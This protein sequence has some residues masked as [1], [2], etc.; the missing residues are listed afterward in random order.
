MLG[1][2]AIIYEEWKVKRFFLTNSVLESCNAIDLLVLWWLLW[3]L[4]GRWQGGVLGIPRWLRCHD[5][6]K[7]ALS[8]YCITLI[9]TFVTWQECVEGNKGWCYRPLLCHGGLWGD[10]Q[11][12]VGSNISQ[13]TNKTRSLVPDRRSSV[14]YFTSSGFSNLAHFKFCYFSIFCCQRAKSQEQKNMQKSQMRER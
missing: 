1:T 4:S 5:G 14:R 11:H 10:W 12:T 6:V 2:L 13:Q 7:I 8:Q 3:N 9:S